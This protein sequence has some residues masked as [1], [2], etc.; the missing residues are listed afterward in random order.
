MWGSKPDTFRMGEGSS[1]A[2][3][4]SWGLAG[5]RVLHW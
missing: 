1:G 3:E 2:S 4:A 5:L